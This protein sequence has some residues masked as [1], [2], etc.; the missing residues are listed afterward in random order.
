H[1]HPAILSLRTGVD[2]NGNFT[3]VKAT[4]HFSGGAYGSQKAN[5]QVTVLGGRRLASM[6]RVPAISCETYCSYTN[7]V[8]CTQTRTP[9]SPQ[10]VFAFES[11]VDIIAKEM[12][13]MLW[14][15]AEEIFLAMAVAISLVRSG[16][17]FACG[18]CWG[19]GC[20]LSV[21]R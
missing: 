11:Q 14:N 1:R 8:P 16:G 2:Q 17:I 9:G 4:I 18:E 10:V 19:G 12:A 20:K 3:A 6:Y 21:G 7:Q 5:P 15:F 13:S